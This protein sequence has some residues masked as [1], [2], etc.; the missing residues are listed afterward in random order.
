[1]IRAQSQ[2][3][4]YLIPYYWSALQVQQEHLFFDKVIVLWYDRFP[5]DDNLLEE[6]DPDFREYR[7]GLRKKVRYEISKKCQL[8]IPA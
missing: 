4:K 8:I 6:P 3:L 2:F 5:E 7:I 1:M